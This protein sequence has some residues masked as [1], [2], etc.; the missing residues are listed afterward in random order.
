MTSLR[1]NRFASLAFA[2][3][4]L[5][6]MATSLAKASAA[7]SPDDNDTP[8]YSTVVAGGQT[9][10]LARYKD[11]TVSIA[12]MDVDTDYYPGVRGHLAYE[13]KDG[14]FHLRIDDTAVKMTTLDRSLAA[15]YFVE[16]ALIFGQAFQHAVPT[17]KP[18]KGAM[19]DGTYDPSAG[20]H[21]KNGRYMAIDYASDEPVSAPL[22]IAP[23][24]R[25]GT[26]KKPAHKIL[27]DKAGQFKI[28]L[29][30]EMKSQKVLRK[31]TAGLV[32]PFP[33]SSQWGS[34]PRAMSFV[35]QV[36]P[37]RDFQPAV[38]VA[39]LTV[40]PT[41]PILMASAAPL[42]HIA[43]QTA[44]PIAVAATPG[45]IGAL[46]FAEAL[47]PD[48]Q[49]HAPSARQN[50]FADTG[51]GAAQSFALNKQAVTLPA[52]FAL[53]KQ[54]TAPVAGVTITT[55]QQASLDRIKTM[56]SGCSNDLKRALHAD[57]VCPSFAAAFH[58]RLRPTEQAVAASIA[59]ARLSMIGQQNATLRTA[60][61]QMIVATYHDRPRPAL[62]AA[63]P[64]MKQAAQPLSPAA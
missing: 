61:D 50:I 62:P 64:A 47:S 27:K 21:D 59:K 14:A 3:A 53:N 16:K 32:I 2:S 31:L 56:L 18:A 43:A 39:A 13:P 11:S 4:I 41:A 24:L 33:T 25:P 22:D 8:Q 38:N 34:A 28:F 17:K 12:E 45:A 30:R 55:A 42:A 60:L 57:V 10:K 51:A 37:Q 40:S 29:A 58:L 26:F 5:L 36:A 7:A 46:H 54:V 49:L 20:P 44:T 15:A 9:V 1:R 63:R 19:D 48:D 6:P 52:A 23:K 35:A